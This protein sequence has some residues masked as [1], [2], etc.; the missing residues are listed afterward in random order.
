MSRPGR[1]RFAG[2]SCRAA[3]I[4]T[5]TRQVGK[6]PRVLMDPERHG[7]LLV[8]PF[9]VRP[10]P[11]HRFHAA[12]RSEITD[13]RELDKQIEMVFKGVGEGIHRTTSGP[14]LVSALE[15]LQER[16]E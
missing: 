6:R 13:R 14:D 3:R 7:C 10:L 16:V 12:A 4:A 8:A 1:W 5:V 9:S 11:E 2:A 15:R